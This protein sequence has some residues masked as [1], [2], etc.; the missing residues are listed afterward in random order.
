MFDGETIQGR[1]CLSALY[2]FIPKVYAMRY[3]ATFP[4]LKENKDVANH[5]CPDAAQPGRVRDLPIEGIEMKSTK[6]VL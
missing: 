5:A 1:I 4:W 3:G 2:S 6:A